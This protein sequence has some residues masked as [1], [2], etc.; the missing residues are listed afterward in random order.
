MK[1]YQTIHNKLNQ[2]SYLFFGV[3]FLLWFKTVLTQFGEFNLDLNNQTQ[4]FLVIINP[5]GSILLLLGISFLIQDKYFV[6]M[7]LL[8]QFLLSFILY[9]NVL[10]YRFYS[11]FI[12]LPTLLQT[13]NFHDLG[14]SIFAL[15]NP[16]DPLFFIDT[17]LWVVLITSQLK[18]FPKRSFKRSNKITIFATAILLISLTIGLAESDRPQ[19]LKR[20]FDRNYIVKYLGMYNYVFY[21]VVQSTLTSTQRA[22][23]ESDDITEIIHYTNSIHAEPNP[24]YFG[25][26][27]GFNVIYVHLESL[28]SF[29]IDYKINGE[30]VTPFLN[31]LKKESDTFYFDNF[32][33][34][35]AQGKTSDA[36]FII[37]NS[38]YGLPQ[39]AVFTTKGL[40][41]YQAAP[42]ILKQHGYT[43]AVFHGNNK[44][45]WNRDVIYKSFGYDHFFDS[46]YYDMAPDNVVNYGLKDKPFF[47]QS[48]PFLEELS[49]PFYAKLI[50]L[51]NHYPYPIAEE[52]AT[53]QPYNSGDRSVDHYF[54]TARYLDEALSQ[55][56]NQ[57]KQ[58]GL[59][60]SSIIILYG[61]HY[62]ISDNHKRAMELV[63]GEEVT[64]F[65]FS[66]LQRVPLFIRIPGVKGELMH[67]FSGQIDLL[68]TLLHL[69]GVESK[70]F[71][72]FGTDLFSSEHRELIPFRNGNFVSPNF[73]RVNNKFYDTAT[74]YPIIRNDLLSEMERKVKYQLE[75]SDRLVNRDLLRFYTPEGFTPVN[76]L[77]YNY[78]NPKE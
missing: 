26:G 47:K 20:M 54:Q 49:Q 12:T 78:Q 2:P 27:K 9:A 61:D 58:N 53:I 17:F 74:G 62:G 6:K 32:F 66:Q 67:D 46:S 14:G 3:S 75:L 30:E 34:Q 21:D 51:S 7:L 36:E 18:G 1:L 29:I 45:F 40:N 22:M 57:L 56:F 76:R 64:S 31:S 48:M 70:E 11:D 15:S 63:L 65:T 10:Y 59:Y 43:S 41:T 8:L 37:D 42:A 24:T 60:E 71:V 23:A 25:V 55:F 77:M 44:S 28:Q 50:T 13:K 16:Y 68:P 5:L 73:T 72:L 39:G 69:L 35:T 4:I 33:H 38:L 52:E 19:L